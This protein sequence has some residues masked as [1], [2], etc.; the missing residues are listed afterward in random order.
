MHHMARGFF[1][2]VTVVCL[3]EAGG[4]VF[5]AVNDTGAALSLMLEV[6]AVRMS[7]SS[8]QLA[9]CR[10]DAP[11]DCA[12]QALSLAHAVLEE[13]EVLSF[14][15]TLPDGAMGR[16]LFAPR[17]WKSYDLHPA[18]L[19]MDARQEGG[20]WQITLTARALAPFVAVEADVPGRFSVNAV[21]L[22]PCTPVTLTFTPADPQAVPGFVLRDLHAA[23]YG[24]TLTGA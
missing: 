9:E 23:T 12:V 21:T 11:T 5:K 6:W 2:P 13:D 10:V 16:D 19:A 24:P 17:P 18:A 22:L 3:P 14:F 1:A 7:G 8:R 20:L 4:W 15:W